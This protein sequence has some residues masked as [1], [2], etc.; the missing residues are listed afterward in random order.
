[1]TLKFLDHALHLNGQL[2][3]E[4]DNNYNLTII[5]CDGALCSDPFELHILVTDVNEGFT[6]EPLT[7]EVSTL[8]EEVIS[9]S[10]GS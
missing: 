9:F 2:N 1:M 6:V 4:V 7:V 3:Y 10:I 5:C 8:E